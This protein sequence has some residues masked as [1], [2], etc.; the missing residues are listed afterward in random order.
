MYELA[1]I[2]I[3]AFQEKIKDVNATAENISYD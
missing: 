2:H 1:R 3:L